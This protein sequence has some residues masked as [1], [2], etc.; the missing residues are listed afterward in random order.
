MA[1]RI[2]AIAPASVANIG[3]LFDSAAMAVEAFRDTVL[4]EE[5]VGGDVQVEAKGPVPSGR[6]NVAYKAAVYFLERLY[7]RLT[8]VRVIVEK[9]IPVAAGLGSS[10]ATA[11]ATVAA[12]N[13]LLGIGAST[14]D[15]IE[16]AG[17]G[18][19]LAAGSRHYDNVAASLLGGVV[20]VDPQNP[21]TYAL[22]RPPR[23]LRVV[24]FVKT[25]DVRE[26]TSFMRRLLPRT[27]GL[28]E[29]SRWALAAAMLTLGL[30]VGDERYIAYASMGGPVE[31]ARSRVIRNYWRAKEEA[32]KAGAIAF[33]LSGAGPSMFAL[34]KDDV[35]SLVAER[36][37]AVIDGYELVITGINMNGVVIED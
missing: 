4:V 2:K 30:S 7:G 19:A 12:L 11:A 24:L 21:R 22:I 14:G 15:L 27:V 23:S 26:K 35:A 25:L 13:E 34:A 37:L 20:L 31:K 6:S 18:E 1:S 10:G 17:E 8:G 29:A 9:G 5:T 16:A 3:C 33:N 32:L 36:V 28:G